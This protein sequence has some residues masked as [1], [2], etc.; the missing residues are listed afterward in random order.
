MRLGHKTREEAL[1]ELNDDIDLDHVR[2]TLRSVG[3]DDSSKSSA[4]LEMG[5]FVVCEPS[6]DLD[7]L[8]AHL[9]Q[10]LPAAWIPQRLQALEALPLTANGKL[11]ETRLPWGASSAPID[12]TPLDGPVEEF[13]AEQ[14]QRVL[15]LPR[16]GATA[17]FFESG[18]TSLGAIEVMVRLCDEFDIEL[19]L[20]ALFE[21]P[22]LR[23]LAGLAEDRILAEVD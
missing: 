19:P 22:V 12:D 11:D 4:G 16:L 23:D 21:T 7:E 17:H 18:G 10:E 15:D 5:A 8:R 14:W 9:A 20:E 13:L 1:A 2:R 6:V 3:Y